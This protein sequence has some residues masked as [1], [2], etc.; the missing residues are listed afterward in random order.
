MSITGEIIQIPGFKK[1]HVGNVLL[2]KEDGT[3]DLLRIIL[4]HWEPMVPGQHITIYRTLGVE[5]MEERLLF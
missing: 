5:R 2:L 1:R 3:G 4:P